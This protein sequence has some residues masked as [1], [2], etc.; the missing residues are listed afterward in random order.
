[1]ESTIAELHWVQDAVLLG[2]M[3]QEEADENLAEL[4]ERDG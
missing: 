3:T 4:E 1:M 2:M